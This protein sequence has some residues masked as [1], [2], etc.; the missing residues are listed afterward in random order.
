MDLTII[1]QGNG[2][3]TKKYLKKTD[4]NGYIPLSS[5]HHPNCLSG[6]LN[7]QYLRIRWNCTD[8]SNFLRQSEVIRKRFV[9][10]GYPKDTLDSTIQQVVST[11]R[12]GILAPKKKEVVR[13][14]LHYLL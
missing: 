12:A 3:I 9:E 5:C 13:V 11:D 2:F 8:T 10:K 7:S 4:R 14:V 1:R 6:I